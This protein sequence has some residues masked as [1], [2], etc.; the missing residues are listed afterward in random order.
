MAASS[1]RVVPG[2]AHI[3]ATGRNV[4]HE[5]VE[6]AEFLGGAGDP[7]L[8]RL[9]VGDIHHRAGDLHA[10]CLQCG[11]GLIHLFLM[12]RADGEVAALICEQFGD[13]AAD[14]AGGA[15]DQCFL[16]G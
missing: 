3:T 4:G 13:G 5:D 8:V 10:L 14:A 15:S 9:L 12:A 1:P 11:D 6:A 16:A 2:F 7:G